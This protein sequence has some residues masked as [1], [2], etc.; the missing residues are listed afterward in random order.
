M[1]DLRVISD[2]ASLRTD[3]G[4]PHYTGGHSCGGDTTQVM[5]PIC[6]C[7]QETPGSLASQGAAGHC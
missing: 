1:H 5:E 2:R 4:V 6:A 7:M 3:L